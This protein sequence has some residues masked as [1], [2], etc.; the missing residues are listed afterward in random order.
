MMRTLRLLFAFLLLLI[1]SFRDDNATVE[2]EVVKFREFSAHNGF[3]CAENSG[4]F[5]ISGILSLIQCSVKCA[6]ESSCLGVIYESTLMR[7]V[8]CRWYTNG[9]QGL[10]LSYNRKAYR[11]VTYNM[12]WV[13]AKANCESLG[14]RLA[15]IKSQE[16]QTFI[17]RNI[18]PSAVNLYWI[19][20]KDNSSGFV[21]LDGTGVS[22]GYNYWHDGEPSASE[23]N[24]EY[25]IMLYQRQDNTTYTWSDAPCE[26]ENFVLGSLCE[27]D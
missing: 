23:G 19:G 18:L 15:D 3:T 25:C 24:V 22:A 10:G 12:N 9:G 14:G 16:E 17:E 26:S 8:G 4:I 11:L 6:S 1:S 13:Q 27:F 2:A 21:W 5:N 7:C 20:G